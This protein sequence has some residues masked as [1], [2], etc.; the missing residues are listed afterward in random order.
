MEQVHEPQHCTHGKHITTSSIKRPADISYMTEIPI[1]SSKRQLILDDTCITITIKDWTTNDFAQKNYIKIDKNAKLEKL[2][3]IYANCR[4]ISDMND[5][6]SFIFCFKDKILNNWS[7]TISSCGM[8][9]NDSID[10]M[11]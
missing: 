9:D 1:P 5:V 3:M 4:G 8:Q 7:D 11:R 2:F 10:C 6:A